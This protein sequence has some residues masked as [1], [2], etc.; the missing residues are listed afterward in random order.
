MANFKIEKVVAKDK[1]GVI[2]GSGEVKQYFET[3]EGLTAAIKDTTLKTIVKNLNRQLKTDCRNNLARKQSL[4]SMLKS[5][6]ASNPAMRDQANKMLEEAG[7][8]ERF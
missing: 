3:Q 8:E 7:I 4:M 2:L 6:I 1:D 5:L